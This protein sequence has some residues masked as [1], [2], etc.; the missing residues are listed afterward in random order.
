MV[1][2]V[3]PRTLISIFRL[4]ICIQRPIMAG[5]SG[6]RCLRGRGL[7]ID[8]RRWEAGPPPSPANIWSQRAR[9]RCHGDSQQ[10][11]C[12]RSFP[13]LFTQ[14]KGK[15]NL[16][17]RWVGVIWPEAGVSSTG[18]NMRESGFL[19]YQKRALKGCGEIKQKLKHHTFFSY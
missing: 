3:Q 12:T 14:Q 1:L 19:P 7:L 17:T 5:P 6:R 8:L 2:P 18:F 10:H 15:K 11:P 9:C 16:V 4:S 13:V